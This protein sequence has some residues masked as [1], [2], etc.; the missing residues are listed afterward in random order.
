MGILANTV[1]ICHYKIA[2]DLPPGDLYAWCA[3]SLARQGFKS[4]ETTADEL[5]LGW[6]HL[7]DFREAGFDSS[8]AFWRDHY[9]AF[10]LRRDQR[11]LPAALLKAGIRSAEQDF[12]AASPGLSR[13]PKQKRE[14][15]K[16]AVRLSLM[17]RT[18]PAPSM[19]DA[20]WDTRSGLVTFA[21]LGNKA[22]ET[23]EI[24]FAKTFGGLRLQALHPIARAAGVVEEPLL[25]ELEKANQAT[26]E[27][28]L[29]QIRSNQWLGWDLLAWLTLRTVTGRQD[30]QVTATGPAMTNEGFSA[31]LDDRMVLQ[32][33]GENGPQKV[34]VA[35]SQEGFGEVRVALQ[36]GKKITEA[37]LHLE[38]GDD[39]WKLTLKG[40]TFHFGSYRTPP[41]QMEKDNTVDAASEQEAVFYERMLLLE[42]GLQLFD[43]ILSRFLAD[44]LTAKWA[45]TEKG[46]QEWLGQ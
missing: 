4:I 35:G 16:E 14:D 45:E 12:L 20:V 36:G 41:V 18:L 17:A 8:A 13:V 24:L 25:P 11:K 33:A 34:T 28:A 23:F 42:K 40:E 5:S 7:D 19:F 3:E 21:S 15:I 26:T 43:S 39:S 38:M 29:D 10:T 37:T 22:R 31:W 32:I 1:S 2:G 44:R 9:V 6:A 30:Y 27:A 46:L